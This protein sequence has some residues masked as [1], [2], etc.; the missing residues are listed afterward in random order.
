MRNIS[1][2]AL[3]AGAWFS[4]HSCASAM[5]RVEVDLNAQRM[6]VSAGSGEQFDW[7]ISSGRPGHATPRGMFHPQ[8]MYVMVHSAKYNNAPMPHSI[9]FHGRYAIHGTDAVWRARPCRLAWLRPPRARQ[10]R[11]AVRDGRARGRADLDR[12]RARRRTPS[13]AESA[14]RR[15]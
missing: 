10:R 9:F 1:R 5:V 13:P 2:L 15:P 4:L 8:A 6:H 7:P 14:P 12:R 3:A 11:D